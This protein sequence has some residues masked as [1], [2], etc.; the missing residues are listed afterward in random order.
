MCV[1]ESFFK[2]LK[3]ELVYDYEFESIEEAKSKVFEWIE[4]WYNKKRLHLHQ[5]IKTPCEVEQEFY[6][7]VNHA[8]Q[9]L[10]N[11]RLFVATPILIRE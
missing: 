9:S 2:T 3:V 11:V 7:K 1:A 5:V 8:A 4:I 6:K 10:K